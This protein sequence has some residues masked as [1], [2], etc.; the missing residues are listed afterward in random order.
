MEITDVWDRYVDD[1]TNMVLR[2]QIITHYVSLADRISDWMQGSLPAQVDRDDLRSSAYFGLIDAVD[3]FDPSKGFK[4]ETFATP[5]I[6]GAVL[7]FLR[8]ADWAPRSLRAKGREVLQK[9]EELTGTLHRDPTNAELAEG[10][11]WTEEEVFSIRARHAR[12]QVMSLHAAD[13]SDDSGW[14]ENF[15]EAVMTDSS[16]EYTLDSEFDF[17]GLQRSLSEAIY[18]LTPKERIVFTLFYYEDTSLAEIGKV[19]NVTESRVCQI[20]TQ[21]ALNCKSRLDLAHQ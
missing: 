21:A 15:M 7:D 1:K 3:R 10:L 5:R 18:D 19:L 13:D 4:F 8:G 9:T 20:L 16:M 11:G 2:D 14:D 17:Q 6:K 12:S